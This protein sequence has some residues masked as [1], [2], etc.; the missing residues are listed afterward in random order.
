MQQVP[1]LKDIVL[2]GGGHTHTLVVKKWG[3]KPLP[4]VRLTLVSRDVLTPY[5]GMLPGYIAGHYSRE[6]THIDLSRLCRWSGVRFIEATGTG[7]DPGSKKLKLEGRPAIAYDILSIDTGST[8]DV[9][10]VPGAAENTVPVKPVHRF[11]E[12]WLGLLERI[13]A[14]DSDKQATAH[15][16]V[17]GAGVGGLELLLA[18]QHSLSDH[19]NQLQLHWF[20]RGEQPLRAQPASVARRA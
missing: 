18:L 9:E 7:I 10:S 15:I 14:G 5:S 11:E 4:G 6:E 19:A 1:I 17:V 16:G 3:M 2:F 12:K 20:V 13:N 8:P